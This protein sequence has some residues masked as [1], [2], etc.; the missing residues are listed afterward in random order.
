MA[1]LFGISYSCKHIRYRVTVHLTNPVKNNSNYLFPLPACLFQS[2]DFAFAGKFP[3][4]E[5]ADS[6]LSVNCMASAA[7]FASSIGPCSEF[8]FL[9]AFI[10]ESFC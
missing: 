10:Y 7:D 4:A 3:Q 5:S 1:G 8:R 2:W 6:E 9:L